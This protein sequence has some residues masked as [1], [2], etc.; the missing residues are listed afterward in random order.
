M[1]WTILMWAGGISVGSV[2]LGQI[3]AWIT[4]RPNPVWE[5]LGELFGAIGDLAGAICDGIGD[6]GSGGD[7]G[8]CDGGGG[9][10]D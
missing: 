5:A 3:Y 7:G 10:G 4:D 9:G 6:L 1:I 2:I 8:S